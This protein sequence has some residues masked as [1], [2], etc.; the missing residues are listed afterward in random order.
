MTMTTAN[1]LP[2]VARKLYVACKKC[3]VDR[4]H[5]VIAHLTSASA[6][7]E[8]EVCKGKRTYKIEEPKMA[9][10]KKAAG[11]KKVSVKSLATQ[12]EELKNKS[13]GASPKPYNMRESFVVD[14]PIS[15]PKFGVGYVVQV[16]AIAIEVLFE[17]GTKSLVHNRQS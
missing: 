10:A 14:T 8:C 2:P 7:V 12:Y 11:V 1:E 17:D 13:S 16:S 9:K 3:G 15:H 6:K 4:Y 5:T